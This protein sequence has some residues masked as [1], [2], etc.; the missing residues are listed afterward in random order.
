MRSELE[1]RIEF[2]DHETGRRGEVVAPMPRGVWTIADVHAFAARRVVGY[3]SVTAAQVWN[4]TRNA[5]VRGA[6]Y[7]L[8]GKQ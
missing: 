5:P 2:L 1:L 4:V 8:E 3:R 7:A 6:H